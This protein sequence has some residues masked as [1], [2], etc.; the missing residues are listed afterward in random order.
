MG[1]I[2]ARVHAVA[3]LVCVAAMTVL[4]RAHAGKT[5][6]GAKTDARVVTGEGATAIAYAPLDTSAPKPAVVY[7]HGVCGRAANG[8]PYFRPGSEPFGWLVCPQANA[9]CPG[10]GA[11]WGGST[12][13]R[14]A[15]V[16]AAVDAVARAHPGAVDAGAPSVLV[17][18]SQGAW[19]AVELLRKKRGNYTG[20]LLI[21]APVAPAPD[22]LRAAGV[23][24]VVLAAGRYDAAFGPMLERARRLA[25]AGFAARFVSLGHVGHTYAAED[26]SVLTE[27]LAWLEGRA[28]SASP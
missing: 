20:V 14:G 10:G 22:E 4:V 12:D 23:T 25:D 1:L 18:F 6:S 21:G 15:V 19:T 16:D 17:G 28:E 7:L 9:P 27:S 3:A 8:C 5:E 11:S 13:A 26:P 2:M 24:R